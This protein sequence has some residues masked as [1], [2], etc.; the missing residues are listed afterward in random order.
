MAKNERKI[1]HKDCQLEVKEFAETGSLT[2]YLSTF[3]NVDLGRDRVEA[4]AFTKTI[5]E[6]PVKALLWHHDPSE[7]SKVVGSFT[8]K[9]DARGLFIDADFLPDPDSQN[10]RTKCRALRERGVTLGLSIGYQVIKDAFE[11]VAGMTVRILKELKL[12]EGSLTLFPMNEMALV[13]GVKSG[14]DDDVDLMD[15]HELD[16]FDDPVTIEPLEEPGK[17]TPKPILEPESIHSMFLAH[18]VWAAHDEFKRLIA[19]L[20][21]R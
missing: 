7:P 2:G 13:S 10:V 17:P 18:Q 21:V 4:G 12:N 20:T 14:G 11:T 19:S 15:D 8:A 5:K 1:E 16:G 3:G 9:E 6:N